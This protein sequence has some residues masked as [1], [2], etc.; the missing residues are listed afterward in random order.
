MGI[1]FIHTGD[2]HLGLQFENASFSSEFA[3]IRRREIWE[4]FERIINR[5]NERKIDLLLISGDLFEEEYCSIGDIKRIRS[6][7]NLLKETR[8]IITAGN[9]DNLSKKSLYKLIDWPNNVIVFEKDYMEKIIFKDLNVAIWGL[10]WENKLEKRNLV[11][12]VNLDNHM[13]NILVVHGDILN[14]D[15][16]YLPIYKENLKGFDYV[17]L[18]HIHKHQFIDKNIAYCGSPEPLDFGETGIHGIIEGTISNGKCMT[19]F[20]PFGKREFVITEIDI[21]SSMDYQDIINSMVSID[22]KENKNKNLYRIILNGF[23]DR[24]IKLNIRDIEGTLRDKFKYIEIINNTRL[25]YDLEKIEEQNNGNII[26]DF[27]R[28][29][30]KEGLNNPLVKEALYEGLEVLFNEKV[31]K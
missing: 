18:G 6:I 2:L 1:S 3:N 22:T 8:V 9:H 28:E 23:I 11:K 29:M 15:S 17:A 30:K 31:R 10:S 14:R 26:G 13:E 5:A 27:I 24:D 19:K 25:D 21:N 4:T 12:H 7:F 20:I 16:M